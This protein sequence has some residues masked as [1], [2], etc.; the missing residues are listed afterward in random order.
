MSTNPFSLR[1]P[2]LAATDALGCAIA[3]AVIEKAIICLSGNLGSGKT[4]L[5]KAVGKA[6]G[7][8][9]VI[10]SPT[11]SVCNEYE[12]GRLPFYHFD[13]YRLEENLMATGSPVDTLAMEIDEIMSQKKMLSMVEWPEA[14]LINQ[15]NYFDN[16]DRINI[17]LQTLEKEERL[18]EI[19][20]CGSL[21]DIV[22]KS[23]LNNLSK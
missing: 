14:F 23:L 22:F 19:Q 5:V 7:I 11:F 10:N 1:L 9:E 6:L 4:H 15:K 17:R 13:F 16:L 18:V 21:S 8:Q 12:S 3:D 20:S 2:N